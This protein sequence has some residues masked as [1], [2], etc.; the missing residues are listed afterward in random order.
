MWKRRNGLRIGYQAWLLRIALVSLPAIL[1]LSL[2]IPVVMAA[3]GQSGIGVTIKYHGKT[4]RTTADSG[5]VGE[6]LTRLGLEVSGED[7]LSHGMDEGVGENMVIV[8]DRVV[9]TQEVYTITIPHTVST[10]RD[11]S[12]PQGVEEILVKGVD[13]ELQ[14]TANVTYINGK[15]T[16][17]EVIR[18]DVTV[19]MVEQIVAQGTGE[20]ETTAP[21]EAVVIGD[22]YITLSTGEVLTYTEVRTVTASAY[23]HMDK[24][25]DSITATGTQVHWGTVAVNPKHIPYGTRMFITSADGSFIYGIACAEDFGGSITKD[26]IDLY[27]PTHNECMQFGRQECTAYFLG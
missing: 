5:T 11:P 25:C 18:R 23:S 10:C 16:A 17:R 26:R 8:I 13:G 24:G 7:V 9:R 14:C 15:E 6:L 2:L 21:E 19:P 12:I 3:T 27:M 4:I 20:P 1:I 22:G